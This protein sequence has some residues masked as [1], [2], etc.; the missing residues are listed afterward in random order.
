MTS[1][2]SHGCSSL[3]YFTL[4]SRQHRQWRWTSDPSHRSK[5]LLIVSVY[6]EQTFFFYLS[7]FFWSWHIHAFFHSCCGRALYLHKHKLGPS[8]TSKAAE[9]CSEQCCWE[10]EGA[11]EQPALCRQCFATNYVIL[12]VRR[13]SIWVLFYFQSSYESLQWREKVSGHLVH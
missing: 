1:N 12:Q 4:T 11:A 6:K 9:K 8:C 7:F 13:V 10:N 5:T 2:A 3:L